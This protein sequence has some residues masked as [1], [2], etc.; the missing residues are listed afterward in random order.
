LGSVPQ[1]YFP[2]ELPSF[3]RFVISSPELS[4]TPDKFPVEADDCFNQLLVVHASCSRRQPH[5]Y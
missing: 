5:I 3:R 2:P 4:V 1:C